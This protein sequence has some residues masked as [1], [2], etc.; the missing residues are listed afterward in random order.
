MSLYR[1]YIYNFDVAF[2]GGAVNVVQDALLFG[3]TI[4]L[5]VDSLTSISCET[6]FGNAD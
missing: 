5:S 1:L 3:T 6:E 2:G 4:K